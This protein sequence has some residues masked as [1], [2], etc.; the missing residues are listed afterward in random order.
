[1]TGPRLC[2][3]CGFVEKNGGFLRLLVCW[4]GKSG[5]FLRFIAVFYGRQGVWRGK[6]CGG[7]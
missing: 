6:S 3:V 7:R 4:C 1:M 5:G 2:I